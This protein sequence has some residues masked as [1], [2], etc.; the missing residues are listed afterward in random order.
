MGRRSTTME[1]YLIAIIVVYIAV[2]SIKNPLF[3]SAEKAYAAFRPPLD[4]SA[5]EVFQTASFALG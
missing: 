5:P 3:F 2:V 4:E 1:R